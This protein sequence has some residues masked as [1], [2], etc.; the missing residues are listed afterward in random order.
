VEFLDEIFSFNMS[1]NF[2]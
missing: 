2:N 1:L